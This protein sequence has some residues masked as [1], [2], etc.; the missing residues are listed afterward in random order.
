VTWQ[1]A[2]RYFFYGGVVSAAKEWWF[3]GRISRAE[4]HRIA[5][6]YFDLDEV[7]IEYEVEQNTKDPL[8]LQQSRHRR[9]YAKEIAALCK[10]E[11]AGVGVHTRANEL[12]AST[13]LNQTMKKHNVRKS[14]IVKILPIALVLVFLPTE[15]ELEA[16]VLASSR[17]ACELEARAAE[18]L[19]TNTRGYLFNP[20][21]RRVRRRAVPGV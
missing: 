19:Y 13:W 9:N 4:N 8:R 11:I 1:D 20:L 17:T 12:V 2:T 5:N 10:C 3:R 7:D 18:E 14:H 16:K 21:G 15:T 6:E